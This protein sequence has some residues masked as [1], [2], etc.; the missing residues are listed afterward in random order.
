MKNSF[1][2]R[3]VFHIESFFVIVVI[4]WSVLK[5][6]AGIISSSKP[7]EIVRCVLFSC[8]ESRFKDN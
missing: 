4:P 2:I 6:F 5:D 8:N 7:H 3:L 1:E